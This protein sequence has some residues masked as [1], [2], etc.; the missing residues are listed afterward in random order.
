MVEDTNKIYYGCFMGTYNKNFKWQCKA[1]VIKDD[2]SKF[3]LNNYNKIPDTPTM[4]FPCDK[5]IPSFFHHLK[6]NY[7]LKKFT[8]C[9]IH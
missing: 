2:A 9:D 1:F 7:E 8:K 5:R 6:I 4:I 3:T